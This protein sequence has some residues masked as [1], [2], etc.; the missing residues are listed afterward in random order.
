ML[1]HDCI[2]QIFDRTSINMSFLST[3][4]TFKRI[5]HRRGSTSG[6]PPLTKAPLYGVCR[7]K[8]SEFFFDADSPRNML[9]GHIHVHNFF[10]YGFAS[11]LS[12]FFVVG[13]RLKTIIPMLHRCVF[14]PN[15]FQHTTARFALIMCSSFRL[16]Y[17][18][19][20]RTLIYATNDL[21]C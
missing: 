5:I 17:P 14:G 6:A 12:I 1:I 18:S 9:C 3:T 16:G 7:V 11:K 4:K 20:Y 21:N 15:P 8:T 13:I 10:L 2:F 19:E